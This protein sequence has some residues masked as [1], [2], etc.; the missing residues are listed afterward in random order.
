MMGKESNLTKDPWTAYWQ[1][2]AGSSCFDHPEINLQFTR[3]WHEHVDALPDDARMLDLATGNGAVARLCAAHAADRGIQLD[4]EA[5]DSAEIDPLAC[6]PE[7]GQHSGGINF[8]GSTRLE[9]LPY[10]D[11][12]FTS[13]VSQFGFEYACESRA[14]AEAARVLAPGGQLRLIIHAKDGAVARDIDERLK[15]MR[16]VLVENG[17]V[18][19]TLELARANEAGDTLA[20]EN[21][22]RQLPQAVKLVM[23]LRG[24]PLPDD[25]ALFYSHE[26]LTLW[27]DRK[28][29]RP[30]DLRKSIEDGW[31]NINDMAIRQEEMLRAVRGKKD[32]KQLQNLFES[33]GL[34]PV[35]I[36]RVRDTQDAQI[37][38]MLNARKPA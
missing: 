36:T 12:M 9:A 19:L 1:T 31:A 28:R 34:E 32:M 17:P 29:Y 24:Q 10:R 22:T 4:V 33:L 23:K 11:G 2:G 30:I 21:K 3:L 26:F 8:L 7:P 18:S 15:R 13:V 38:W 37:A 25:S 6:L 5:I 14:A 20:L 27:V 35:E 16:S